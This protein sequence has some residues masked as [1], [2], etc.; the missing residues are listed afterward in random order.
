[1]DH[2]LLSS[3]FDLLFD[4]EKI[5]MT[6]GIALIVLIVYLENGVLIAFFLPGD[7]L[8]FLSGLFCSSGLL[9]INIGIL[10]LLIFLAA[11]GGCFTGYF[12]GKRVSY[13]LY[14]R[15]E[16]RFFKRKYLLDTEVFFNKWGGKSII[17]SRFLPV[18]RTFIPILAG[19]TKYKFKNFILFT[20]TGVAIWVILLVLGGYF[21][22]QKF[23]LLQQYVHYIVIGFLLITTFTLIKSWWT[24]RNNIQTQATKGIETN[25]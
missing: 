22:G 3:F 17:L 16:S 11:V 12:F 18:I 5:I 10:A 24:V 8:L 21:L 15:K 2:V 13:N 19:I 4:S 25:I 6:G 14:N 1:M 23:P 20:L 7:Y 9:K